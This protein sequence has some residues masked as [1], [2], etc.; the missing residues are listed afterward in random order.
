M[1]SAYSGCNLLHGFRVQLSSSNN[2]PCTHIFNVLVQILSS[3]RE[4]KLFGM[5]QKHYGCADNM[6]L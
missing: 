6:T 5:S 4:N 2:V 3:Q 1:M